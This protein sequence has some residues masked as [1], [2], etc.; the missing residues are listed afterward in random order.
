M[1]V[2]ITI[3]ANMYW[4]IEC[5]QWQTFEVFY[6]YY[7]L[8]FIPTLTGGC[9]YSPLRMRNSMHR[10]VKWLSQGHTASWWPGWDYAPQVLLIPLCWLPFALGF[11]SI[12]NRVSADS[13]FSELLMSQGVD[14]WLSRCSVHTKVVPWCH[15]Q[16]RGFR[17]RGSP[18]KITDPHIVAVRTL[19]R[20]LDLLTLIVLFVSMLA[21]PGSW[22]FL[23]RWREIRVLKALHQLEGLWQW[24][25]YYS[26]TVTH[27]VGQGFVCMW[28][29][30]GLWGVHLLSF[31]AVRGDRWLRATGS[32]CQACISHSRRVVV[33]DC[34]LS[35]HD[36]CAAYSHRDRAE[37]LP[38]YPVS[39]EESLPELT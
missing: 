2:I 39:R 22:R 15:A 3:I 1:I 30:K 32:F 24:Y 4:F 16:T 31:P 27:P 36:E 14:I 17:I 37:L 8:I 25:F 38:C 28:D 26:M 5:L 21:I 23:Y 20:L 29:Q 6:R 35:D 10:E 19:A 13:W 18:L 33:Q 34:Q 9:C 7:S 11:L 12:C